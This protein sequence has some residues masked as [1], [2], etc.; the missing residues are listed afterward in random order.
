MAASE[1]DE[2]TIRDDQTFNLGTSKDF[3]V[4]YDAADNRLE[5]LDS[6]NS[7][8]AHL[9]TAGALTLIGTLTASGIASAQYTPTIT[10]V[11]NVASSANPIGY[12]ARLGSIVAFAFY[13]DITPTAGSNAAT[14]FDASFP[15]ASA[16]TSARHVIG[17]GTARRA[18]NSQTSARVYSNTTDDRFT[19]EFGSIDT[20]AHSV[21][22]AGLM[23]L[24]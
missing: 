15:I 16:T 24:I 10:G 11:T 13:A 20:S 5:F 9:S 12:Y 6:S 3:K 17:V 21:A 4:K 2:I 8:I 7:V 22:C 14:V 19:V 1:Y 23:I 18:A